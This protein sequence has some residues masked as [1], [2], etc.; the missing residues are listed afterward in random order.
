MAVLVALILLA[1]W[2]LKRLIRRLARHRRATA[3]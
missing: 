2:L 3:N 1:G